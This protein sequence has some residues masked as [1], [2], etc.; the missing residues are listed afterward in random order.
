M[1]CKKQ[2]RRAQQELYRYCYSQLMS[3]CSRYEKNEEDARFIL[4]LGFMK[5]IDHIDKYTEDV[6]FVAWIRRIMINT[7]IDEFRKNK[8]RKE[9]IVLD[10]GETNTYEKLRY[11]TNLAAEQFEAE[12]LEGYIRR[13]PEDT[14]KVFNMFAIDGYSHK[15]IS[16]MLQMSIGTSKWHVSRAR[17]MVIAM[18]AKKS[19][20]SQAYIK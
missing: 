3:V 13:L 14:R 12:E 15:E 10:D 7:V 17:K 1:R 19:P 5:I 8:K 4:N 6:P 11:D 20:Q 9:T 2:D 18:I 16:D